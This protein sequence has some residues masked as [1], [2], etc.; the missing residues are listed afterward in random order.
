MIRLSSQP[1]HPPSS[2]S[3]LCSEIVSRVLAHTQTASQIS[4]KD[5]P[6]AIWA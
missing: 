4:E 6:S 3:A 2:K 5:R 1:S